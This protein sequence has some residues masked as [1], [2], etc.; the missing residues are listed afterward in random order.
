[1]LP[2]IQVHGVWVGGG[3]DLAWVKQQRPG[4]KRSPNFVVEVALV[5]VQAVPLPGAV[6]GVHVAHSLL[7]RRHCNAVLLRRAVEK[8]IWQ[9]AVRGRDTVSNLFLHAG[10]HVMLPLQYKPLLAAL[11]L[12]VGSHHYFATL[13]V[14]PIFPFAAGTH[15]SLHCKIHVCCHTLYAARTHIE[16]GL[17]EFVLPVA[18]G[19]ARR[20]GW[21]G[22]VLLLYTPAGR[23]AVRHASLSCACG[24]PSQM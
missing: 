13:G 20:G 2:L 23:A 24:V 6:K 4:Q 7:R 9:C 1:M 22:W 11:P 5:F 12:V 8:S 19:G 3:V 16:H 21:V 10:R 18:A 14:E 15:S 17:L